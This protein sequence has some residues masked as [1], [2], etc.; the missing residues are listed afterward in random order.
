MAWTEEVD[1]HTKQNLAF[2]TGKSGSHRDDGIFLALGPAI[3]SQAE[4]QK[5]N[6]T[7]VAPT[8]L[9]LAGVPIPKE[10]DG[11]VLEEILT[12]E[13]AA[14]HPIE[15]SEEKSGPAATEAKDDY[16]NQ[17]EEAIADRLRSLGY[18]E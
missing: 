10:M 11:R 15:I 18:I 8:I 16:S 17:D 9:H 2:F 5:A 14:S 13:F 3:Q 4:T 1:P 12:P 6:I 7:D